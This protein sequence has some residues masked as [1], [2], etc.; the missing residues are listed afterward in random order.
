MKS[1]SGALS[2][3]ISG[4]GHQQEICDCKIRED[5]VCGIPE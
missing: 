5:Y 4:G 1:N 3:D 2:S